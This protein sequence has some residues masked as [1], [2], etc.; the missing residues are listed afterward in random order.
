MVVMAG[1]VAPCFFLELLKEMAETK[2]RAT[3][4]DTLHR[5]RKTQ[6]REA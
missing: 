2:T 3:S 1:V 6:P 4:N 5:S